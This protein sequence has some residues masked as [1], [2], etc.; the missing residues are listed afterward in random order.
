MTPDLHCLD[1][2]FSIWSQPLQRRSNFVGLAV[3]TQVFKE[4]H[5]LHSCQQVDAW[6]REKTANGVTTIREMARGPAGSFE[7][8]K[9]EYDELFEYGAWFLGIGSDNVDGEPWF[10]PTEVNHLVD[11]HGSFISVDYLYQWLSGLTP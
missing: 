5:Y 6:V 9:A 7:L 4:G 1:I 8:L 10:A 2:L 11:Q 3:V